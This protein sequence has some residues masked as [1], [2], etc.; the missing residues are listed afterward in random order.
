MIGVALPRGPARWVRRG[1]VPFTPAPNSGVCY[2]C[3][4]YDGA[5]VVVANAGDCRCVL[6]RRRRGPHGPHGPDYMAV[7]MSRDH[8]AQ[9][10]AEREAVAR[11]TRGESCRNQYCPTMTVRRVNL[12]RLS[13]CADP[14]PFRSSTKSRL[15]NPDLPQRVAGSLMVTRAMGDGYLKCP[16]LSDGVFRPY[17]PYITAEPVRRH[18]RKHACTAALLLPLLRLL[19]WAVALTALYRRAPRT[20]AAGAAHLRRE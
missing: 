2:L 12:P 11:R 10:Q 13:A 20:A 6:A 4:V 16:S 1:A 9:N 3:V 17:C 19:Q 8:T 14:M 18:A 7:A 15:I 5:Q